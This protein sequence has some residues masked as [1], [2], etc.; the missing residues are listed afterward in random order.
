MGADGKPIER[1]AREAFGWE[2]LRPGQADAAAAVIDGRDTLAVMSTGYGKS[3]IYQIAA[4]LIPGPTGVV[5]PLI[6]LQRD[7][8]EDLERQAAGGAAAVSSHVRQSDRRDALEELAD[9]ELEFLFLSPEQLSNEEVLA[10]V[11]DEA[12]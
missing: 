3:A 1:V 7:Q 9:D 10:E 11:A 5:S 12:P 8:V 2:E 6:A 4:M